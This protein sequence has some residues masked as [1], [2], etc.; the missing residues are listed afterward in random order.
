MW[1]SSATVNHQFAGSEGLL[2]D[3]STV[4]RELTAVISEEIE[5]Q[6][7]VH[8]QVE[9][10]PGLIADAI[11]DAF[12]VQ[13][14]EGSSAATVDHLAQP[15]WE[16]TLARPWHWGIAIILDQAG[17]VPDVDPH[18][19]VS[20][21]PSG[22]VVL[23]RHAQDSI[24][25]FDGDWAWATATLHIRLLASP[26]P[27]PGSI[28]CDAVL[29]TPSGLLSVGDADGDMVLSTHHGRTRVI[30]SV[31][32][33]ANMSPASVWIDLVSVND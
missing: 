18:Q 17:D 13:P 8:R 10:I 9:D 15:I 22:L 23:V 31:E 7:G 21:G 16:V 25:R 6:L 11:L 3:D 29:H 32:D 20:L 19:L 2:I 26:Q 5:A 12:W 27:A 1:S 24:E 30:V 28:A 33:L 4:V 14:R